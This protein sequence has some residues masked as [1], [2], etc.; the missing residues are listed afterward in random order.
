MKNSFKKILLVLVLGFCLIGNIQAK[1]CYQITKESTCLNNSK[2]IWMSKKCRVKSCTSLKKKTA[3][4]KSS[5]SSKTK[6]Q[7]SSDDKKCSSNSNPH[8]SD[9]SNTTG[10]SMIGSD[11][12]SNRDAKLTTWNCV[13]SKLDSSGKETGS[14]VTLT[15]VADFSGNVNIQ[16]GSNNTTVTINT[17][18]Y[19]TKCDWIENGKN[20]VESAIPWNED[21][22]CNKLSFEQT[23]SVTSENS[24]DIYLFP[25]RD[26][27]NQIHYIMDDRNPIQVKS[28]TGIYDE[29]WKLKYVTHSDGSI[30]TGVHK[31]LSPI[32]D[33]NKKS[34]KYEGFY[35]VSVKYKTCGSIDRI[36]RFLPTFTISLY[37]TIKFLVP[38]LLIIMGIK[39]FVQ[40]MVSKDENTMKEQQKKFIKRIIASVIIF[41]LLSLVQFFIRLAN[42]DNKED[43]LSCIDCLINNVGSCGEFNYTEWLNSGKTEESTSSSNSTEKSTSSTNKKVVPYSYN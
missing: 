16:D 32:N 43:T 13:Y 41:F 14:E 7:W 29:V 36:P 27:V 10:S 22:Y 5:N 15:P 24:C 18:S 39:D 26:Y 28:F 25:A 40:A 35:D 4:E 30:S 2:C 37:K 19:D 9:T 31:E 12:S 20:I 3:C 33:R 34:G 21:R 6:C 38:L 17:G 23:Y 1:E 11:Q 42:S 8:A